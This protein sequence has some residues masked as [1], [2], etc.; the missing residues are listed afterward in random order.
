MKN[1]LHKVYFILFFIGCFQVN[2]QT[3]NYKKE[4]SKENSNFFEIVKKTRKQFS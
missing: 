3:I 2:A 4:A 1:T